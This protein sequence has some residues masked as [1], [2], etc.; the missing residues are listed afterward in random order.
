MTYILSKLSGHC[1][2]FIGA[3][4]AEGFSDKLFSVCDI[5]SK[6][7]RRKIRDHK[8]PHSAP[9]KTFE[10][11]DRRQE[12][13]DTHSFFLGSLSSTAATEKRENNKK[14]CS[15]VDKSGRGR[16]PS[17]YKNLGVTQWFGTSVKQS[18]SNSHLLSHDSKKKKNTVQWSSRDQLNSSTKASFETGAQH[19]DEKSVTAG[20]VYKTGIHRH[21]IDETSSRFVR[22]RSWFEDKQK[23]FTS[24]KGTGYKFLENLI[25]KDPIDVV[26]KLASSKTGFDEMLKK[27][28][29]PDLIHLTIRILAEKVCAAG[30][31]HN[32]TTV[33]II[34]CQPYFL[35]Q[36][37][38]QINKIPTEQQSRKSKILPFLE[39]LLIFYET[40]LNV[41]PQTAC[42]K[43]NN[44]FI[45][46]ELSIEGAKRYQNINC[47]DI[48]KK[49]EDVIAQL[50]SKREEYEHSPIKTSSK[51]EQLQ[52]LQPPD[53]FR[54][55]SIFPTVEDFANKPF[56]RPSIVK[57]AYIDVEH[58]L[59]VQ[60]RLLRE[61]FVGPL[62]E[63][64]AQYM[65]HCLQGQKRFKRIDNVRIYRDAQ[66]VNTVTV[67]EKVGVLLNFDT[68]RKLKNIHWEHSKRFMFGS[69]LCFTRDNFGTFFFGT[70]LDRDKKQL[71]KGCVMVELCAEI[72]S[73][74]FYEFF[75]V[76]ESEVYFEPY[77]QV[78]NA[79]QNMPF[80]EF[81]MKPYIVDGI[82]EVSLPQ[83]IYANPDSVVYNIDDFRVPVTELDAWPTEDELN[84]DVSQYKSFKSALTKEFV[85]I[86]GPPG[87]GK[88]FLGLKIIHTFL[89]NQNI[90]NIN[91]RPIL[92]V[93][94][95]NHAL[96]QVL[97][98]T[99][100]HTTRIIRIGGQSQS[101]ALEPYNLKEIR[102]TRALKL[103][104]SHTREIFRQMQD[105]I[106][107]IHSLQRDIE[108]MANNWGV[109]S[110]SSLKEM[111][112]TDKQLVS[113]IDKQ[114]V[115][116]ELFIEWLKGDGNDNPDNEFQQGQAN[117]YDDDDNNI[118][119][120]HDEYDLVIQIVST[121]QL[122]YALQLSHLRAHSQYCQEQMERS[123]DNQE[124]FLKYQQLWL[125][126]TGLY[127]SLQSAY[128]KFK[129]RKFQ[130]EERAR[131]L[132]PEVCMNTLFEFRSGLHTQP[133]DLFDSNIVLCSCTVMNKKRIILSYEI[134]AE[135]SLNVTE[136]ICYWETHE[137]VSVLK[138]FFKN[139]LT[140]DVS[141]DG[142]L[143]ERLTRVHNLWDLNIEERWYLYKYWC[144]CLHSTLMKRVWQLQ[145]QYKQLCM[146]YDE[147]RDIADLCIMQDALVV[148]LTTSGA[149]RKQS[150]L[151]ELKPRIVIV[152]EAAEVLESH[153]VI[154]LT[155]ACEHLILI[156]DHKQ[157]R[158]STAVFELAKNFNFDISL[159]ER[160]LQ[161][162]M[163]YD[164]LE[165][166]HRMRPEIANLITPMIYPTL[167][168]APSVYQ[169]EKVKGVT[170]NLFFIN[171][172]FHEE[173]V[174][175]IVS[176][177][178][179]FEAEFLIALCRYLLLQGYEETEIT[180]LTTYSG[181]MF[182]LRKLRR[183]SG[184]LQNIRITVVDNFQGEENKIILLSL[185]RSNEDGKIGFLKVE[186]R[187]CVALSR[188][189][190]GFYIIGN[191]D[192]LT[193]SSQIWPKINETLM[194]QDA[195]GSHLTLKCQIHP[196]EET[197]VASAADFKAVPEGGCSLP[198][199][200]DLQC[201]HKCQS[202]CHVRNRFHEN[203]K[204]YFPCERIPQ[205]C[206]LGHKCLKK[207]FQDCGDCKMPM[208]NVLP[209][210]HVKTLACHVNASEYQCQEVVEA[211][212]E[213]CSHKTKKLCFQDIQK[214][215]CP[216]PCEDRL[217]CGHSCVR[218][219]HAGDDPDHLEYKCN[220]PC[221]KNNAG[222]K[223]NHKC[224]KKCYEECGEC[225]VEVKVQLSCGHT[226]QIH[227]SS[228]PS[229]VKC[230]RNCKRTMECGHKCHLLCFEQCGNCAV[231]VQK[232]IPDCGHEVLAECSKEPT[233]N[234]C[235]KTCKRLLPCGHHCKSMCRNPC[236][237]QC[238]ELVHSHIRPVCGHAVEIPCYLRSKALHIVVKVLHSDLWKIVKK[239]FW[240][241]KSLNSALLLEC[242]VLED[243]SSNALNK[244]TNGQFPSSN[245]LLSCQSPTFLKICPGLCTIHSVVPNA[246]D[247]LWQL[248]SFTTTIFHFLLFFC[249]DVELFVFDLQRS[250]RRCTNCQK[251]ATSKSR[252]CLNTPTAFVMS[253]GNSMSSESESS[254]HI[255]E[256][257]PQYH[258]SLPQLFNQKELN[259]LVHDLK[260]SKQQAELFESRLQQWNLL[261]PE[262]KISCFR[263][264]GA[265]S[266]QYF[267]MQ[268]SMCVCRDVSG[269]MMQLGV[270]HNS[271]V[272]RLFIDSSK[273]RL[274]VVLLHNGNAFPSVPLAYAVAMIETYET[275][276]LLFT[277]WI[278]EYCCFLCLW[279]SCDTKNHYTVKEWP[280][281]K[282]YVPGNINVNNTP[283]MKSSE[284]LIRHQCLQNQYSNNLELQL[285]FI[286]CS[287]YIWKRLMWWCKADIA[288]CIHVLNQVS[289]L[290]HE[291]C[292]VTDDIRNKNAFHSGEPHALVDL[293]DEMSPQSI[294]GTVADS[295]QQGING[296]NFQ[297]QTGTFTV[298]TFPS[299]FNRQKI[300][301]SL[302]SDQ[303]A[304]SHTNPT[305]KKSLCCLNLNKFAKGNYITTSIF[306]RILI[307]MY[308]KYVLG[309]SLD[310]IINAKN[311][312][313]GK[314]SLA[315][316]EEIADEGWCYK[317]VTV[318]LPLLVCRTTCCPYDTYF[319]Y[320]SITIFFFLLNFDTLIGL[321]GLS[322]YSAKLLSR[323]EMPCGEVLECEHMCAGT[324]G[325]CH[326]GRLHLPC[327]EK[328]G[329]LQICGHGCNVDCA[330][331]CPPCKQKCE[332]RCKHSRCSLKCGV[333]CTPC[334]EPCEWRCKHIRCTKLCYELCNR[335]PCYEPCEKKLKCGHD[336]V[337]FC[338]E[339][340]PPLCRICNE[341]ELTTIFFGSEDEE[342]ARFVYLEDCKHTI[343]SKALDE[344]L[345]QQ[346]VEIGLKSCPLCKTSIKRT[347]RFL[348]Y[349]KISYID[350]QNIKKKVFGNLKD[351]DAK[352][353]Q[354]NTTLK[355]IVVPHIVRRESTE[356]QE[357]L[358]LLHSNLQ[359][360][361]R[362]RQIFLSKTDLD[363]LSIKVE[364]VSKLLETM[365][366]FH[367]ALNGEP[368]KKLMKQFD[369]LIY[370][371]RTRNTNMS[372]QEV[373]DFNLEINRFMRVA[374]FRSIE[375][376][377]S[378]KTSQ[379]DGV[380]MDLHKKAVQEVKSIERYTPIQDQ[381]LKEVLEKLNKQLKVITGDIER[382]RREVVKAVG[383]RSG[384]WFKC[385]NGHYYVIGNCGGA[386]H[387][388]RCPDCK[389]TI[390]GV[391]YRLHTGNRHAGELDGSARP[392]YPNM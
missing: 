317:F 363:S 346:N 265:S 342:D 352:R 309:N 341:E 246:Y 88:T 280:I 109:V 157:L 57:G 376:S 261:P 185:V 304:G 256:Y 15:N 279:D 188:A 242:V 182:Y 319:L 193:K 312:K 122:K 272:W 5:A 267:D 218:N 391:G 307:N 106:S 225:V 43:F 303:T 127:R 75:T 253:V 392:A 227:C 347:L 187:V 205:Q 60:F 222:C 198:C 345:K 34:A 93:C 176:C 301:C 126:N 277:G 321:F 316:Y 343:E 213:P 103:S 281:R 137:N 29:S 350:I 311:V 28:M 294:L 220:K 210:T 190:E 138:K 53:N 189:K 87:T 19:S 116:D 150:L 192:T 223:K 37:E 8:C 263:P 164:C 129:H 54:H 33:L 207:C 76:A 248:S 117:S 63:G 333:P 177:R 290:C 154:S 243:T 131:W 68:K 7:I 289:N 386:V 302:T 85:I 145:A 167:K 359:N 25:D 384:H 170:K 101:K 27:K 334:R 340:C 235:R 153:V 306:I 381:K 356:I 81:P 113:F 330:K 196:T 94:Y 161:N 21:C 14:T 159:F 249:F 344:W 389:A 266:T 78:L 247:C 45:M 191:M 295:G 197:K 124:D 17:K 335:S 379:S 168:S 388:G 149:A 151:Q 299:H 320:D 89:N 358:T 308:N 30:F 332:Y 239:L 327:Q 139:R 118:N 1:D 195:F 180:I 215:H 251:M 318:W 206:P 186:N 372:Q 166:Q 184:A 365:N 254:E 12:E 229:E 100:Q 233:R 79:L 181:Q 111:G 136:D 172:R 230:R 368:C 349:L 80:T 264:R 238:E 373:N 13:E 351:N 236:T 348:N 82:T 293:N 328:C 61:D 174:S 24:I 234:M 110:V 231:K 287:P 120:F 252:C 208:E 336:C 38:G 331:S 66:F 183:E 209:C 20:G 40:V 73:N 179:L 4:M 353:E 361:R 241:N 70:V 135:L 380:V 44:L 212:L 35:N 202:V 214:L 42:E 354:L 142:H 375:S 292:A 96:D 374:Q 313:T 132:G 77:R 232:V 219:C 323:C 325:K 16:L 47:D 125:Y 32:K 224:Y 260:L 104:T 385:Q 339:P 162:G 275:M 152:E 369:R 133:I 67:K 64:I 326:Q 41:L 55:Y 39:N 296:A 203:Y 297:P 357:M 245:I 165:V 156:G 298:L 360:V 141:M 211:V 322:P 244:S 370:L 74:M 18:G 99:L 283:L 237:S 144:Q 31:Q 355:G 23:S 160:M 291:L 6:E 48:K 169:Y 329:R 69:L 268:N 262:T 65:E 10:P 155:K 366:I 276:P 62:R 143:T 105:V 52:Y 112:L 56:L 163:Q 282:S 173:E 286:T 128:T 9:R 228:D 49:L 383:E 91:H 305:Y 200:A 378:F 315:T 134:H 271:Q 114:S 98:G 387:E 273:T 338:G 204:C 90:W 250:A 36:L 221:E 148:G 377:D 130:K 216:F 2:S 310:I 390:G 194:K 26:V 84:L 71:E 285:D 108:K 300:H 147:I 59:D 102:R 72:D 288:D 171:H 95:T 119:V 175:E 269:L 123:Q 199:E 240:R 257:C 140:Q 274:K 226:H 278:R 146:R 97:E 158:P 121:I 83:Y 51:M 3:D 50:K 255:E 362:K 371:M 178:N 217:V 22:N 337:G 258:N 58:Y 115:S 201:G 324:C 92:V 11:K 86:Q 46:T 364:F 284:N 314:S 382:I 367:K 107:H 259:N 270:Q